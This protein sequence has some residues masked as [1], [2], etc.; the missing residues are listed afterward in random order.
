MKLNFRRIG[1]FCLLLVII[2]FFCP[3]ACDTN[4][5]QIANRDGQ[6]P[7]LKAA[8]YVLFIAAIA[9]IIVGIMLMANKK[10]PIIIDWFITLTCMGCGLIPFFR[11][12]KE[13][14][15]Y[16]QSG[17]YFILI[18]IILSFIF[19]L[20]ASV[21]NE[22]G[23]PISMVGSIDKLVDNAGNTVA[24]NSD[25]INDTGGGRTQQ[26]SKSSVLAEKK[27]MLVVESARLLTAPVGSDETGGTIEKG[28]F[29]LKDAENDTGSGVVWCRV[30]KE[31]GAT[32]WCP[33]DCISEPQS[34]SAAAPLAAS[35][36][37]R[38]FACPSCGK[39]LKVA[40]QGR[41]RCPGCQSILALDGN[42]NCS[43]V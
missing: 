30:V 15:R 29:V 19:L 12:I 7:A 18:G 9:G 17:A 42:G 43:I 41:F 27:L 20:I 22:Q 8:L 2:G 13:W 35:V 26:I 31:D 3:I 16:Y 40:G 1:C 5:F 32:G 37:P 36:F 39:K 14:G 21:M 28:E 10:V 11:N 6:N 24:E 4:G 38:I 34:Q 25:P 33:A 23:A